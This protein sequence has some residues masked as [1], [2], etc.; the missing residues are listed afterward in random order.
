M[1]IGT[2]F[3]IGIIPLVGQLNNSVAGQVALVLVASFWP[4]IEQD[5]YMI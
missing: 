5:V 3:I 1:F 4:V 2:L